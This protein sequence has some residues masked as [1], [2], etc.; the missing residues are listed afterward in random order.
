MRFL[1]SL[2]IRLC[3]SITSPIAKEVKDPIP[4]RTYRLD[5][6]HL[7]YYLGEFSSLDC[8]SRGNETIEIRP[9]INRH[10]GLFFS[11]ES[12]SLKKR[13]YFL[14]DFSHL[15]IRE[16]VISLGSKPKVSEVKVDYAVIP[17]Y[18]LYNTN[19]YVGV[20]VHSLRRGKLSIPSYIEILSHEGDYFIGKLNAPLL[21]EV[22][23]S[24]DKKLYSWI[25][26]PYK[27]D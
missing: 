23:K 5:N 2:F 17:G 11:I 20:F 18:A 26:H 25:E 7:I 13:L 16:L 8:R 4:G 21:R 12:Y 10:L 15:E 9:I 27:L 1:K 19:I 6:E 3:L 24:F 22:S 14:H